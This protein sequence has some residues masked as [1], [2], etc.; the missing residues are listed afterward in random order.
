MSI[1]WKMI[2]VSLRVNFGISVLKYRFTRE[3]KK[4]WEPILIGISALLGLGFF[5][6][7]STLIM[8][9]LYKGASQPQVGSP[10]LVLT[11]AF[12]A[13]Q[14]VIFFFGI[15]YIISSF[16]FS[17]DMNILVPLPLKPYHIL[18]SKF[19]VVMV[20]E[21]L[22]LIPFLIPAIIIYGCG[23]SQGIV[24]W[25]KALLLFITSPAIPLI[26]AAL[27][28]V[29]IMRFINLRKSRDL[30]AIIGGLFGLFLA[31]GINFLAQSIPK[32]AG[33]NTLTSFAADKAHIIE[34]IGKNFPPSIWAT[35]SLSKNGF[36]G[37]GYLLLFIGVAIV[38]F[39]LL[40]K[41]A[42][43]VFF[44]AVLAGQES[45][46]KK[47]A[48][49][50]EKRE[51]LYSQSSSTV[52]AI[53]KREWKLLFRTPVFAMNCLAGMLVGPIFAVMPML[54]KNS[55]MKFLTDIIS[56]KANAMPASLA[57]LGLMLFSASMNMVSSTS[58]SREGNMFWISKLIPVSAE[59]QIKGKLIHSILIT[60]IGVI[61][62]GV[63]LIL[64]FHLSFIRVLVIMILGIIGTVP[65][66]IYG[67]LID[68]S[69]PKLVWTNPQ[70]AVKSNL[71]GIL[72]M[73]ASLLIIGILA[74]VSILIVTSHFQDWFCYL[75]IG[76][77]MVVIS[78]PGY[79]G[80]INTAKRKYFTIEV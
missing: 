37:I 36:A 9:V 73:A 19:V 41:L 27:F 69:H 32:N 53:F 61:V 28:D 23:T 31:L 46:K 21:Y 4:L 14:L 45:I 33:M 29:V 5:T 54:A 62:T 6:A 76:V 35:F 52:R 64:M 30:L 49:S 17:K 13:G 10:E 72:G 48:M 43:L 20:N 67:L 34:S 8:I 57:A 38:L 25:L 39:L 3:K 24:Y 12:L 70:E 59:E 80:L 55:N 7:M 26:I 58:V 63:V 68:L 40:L 75:A 71:N 42:D 65:M 74:V 79:Y 22:T 56:N 44:K 1:F 66:S 78:I 15:F 77:I 60:L 50:R 2:K 51:A 16:Y 11:F 18:G 47:K